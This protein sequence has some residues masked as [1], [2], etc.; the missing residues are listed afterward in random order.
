MTIFV[1]ST[2]DHSV[3]CDHAHFVFVGTFKKAA[4]NPASKFCNRVTP[5]FGARKFLRNLQFV[6]FV[7]IFFPTSP[8]GAFVKLFSVK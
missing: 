5:M 7:M 2:N 3:V 8:S 6:S 1:L 4:T